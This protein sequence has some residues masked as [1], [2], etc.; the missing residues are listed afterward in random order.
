MNI[1]KMVKN[2]T[3][4]F[5]QKEFSFADEAK[6][7]G[8]SKLGRYVAGVVGG[9]VLA[10]AVV[11]GNIFYQ[12][13]TM[14]LMVPERAFD[15]QYDIEGRNGLFGKKITIYK[16]IEND[17]HIISKKQYKQETG[18]GTEEIKCM[19]E[20]DEEIYFPTLEDIEIKGINLAELFKKYLVF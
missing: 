6:P 19:L 8:K 1:K 2:L 12:L 15:G 14:D 17:R 11:G 5:K 4:R 3:D 10:G 13:A 18:K 16:N 9:V 7:R 20:Q